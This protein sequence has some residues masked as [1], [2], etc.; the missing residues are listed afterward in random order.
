[1]NTKSKKGIIFK[2][3]SFVFCAIF[4]AFALVIAGEARESKAAL[5]Y[6]Y[7][8][9]NLYVQDDGG[10][11]TGDWNAMGIKSSASTYKTYD[12]TLSSINDINEAQVY[13][14]N[15][16]YVAS[17]QVRIVY[18]PTGTVLTYVENN[19]CTGKKYIYA[20]IFANGNPSLVTYETM[21]NN[22]DTITMTGYL[23]IVMEFRGTEKC[24]VVNSGST[25]FYSGA[26]IIY[27]TSELLY[28]AAVG[29]GY[30]ANEG[31]TSEGVLVIGSSSV[32]G[33][34]SYFSL[35]PIVGGYF[36]YYN[37][38]SGTWTNYGYFKSGDVGSLNA[39]YGYEFAKSFT[40][41]DNIKYRFRMRMYT[42]D[43]NYS[44]GTNYNTSSTYDT[45]Y[46]PYFYIDTT[47]PSYS[48]FT[49]GSSS[50][51]TSRTVTINGASDGTA[52]TTAGLASSPYCF[53]TSSSTSAPG[54]SSCSWQSSASKSFTSTINTYVHAYIRD[55][56]GNVKYA[57]YQQ[58]KVDTTNPT[59]SYSGTSTTWTASNRTITL[60]GSDSHSGVAGYYC[61]GSWVSSTAS[62]YSCTFSTT[63]K[64]ATVGVKD[65]VGNQSTATVNVYVDKTAPTLSTSGTSTTWTTSNRTITLTGSDSHSGVAGYYCNGSW[66]SSTASS[67]SCTFSTSTKTATV[68]VKDTV[69]NQTTT[70]VNVY[71]D[72]TAPSLSASGTSTTWT[73][74][75]RTITLTSSD[76]HSGVAGYYCNGSWVSSTASSYSCTF[77]TS[78]KTATVGVKDTVGNQTTT[79]VNV[80]VDKTAPS[81]SASGT[82]TTWTSSNR[83]ITLT[84]SDSHS[85]VAGYYCNGSWV[86][87]TASSY[88]CTF[89][90]TTTT[91]TVGVKDG[92]GYQTTTTVNVY[93]DKTAPTSSNIS[94]GSSSWATSRT[95][96][97]SSGA[98]S[99]SG[100]NS[101]AYCFVQSTS[102]TAPGTS[103]CS[104]Q[105]SASIKYSSTYNGYAHGY[106]RDGVSNVKY[107]SYTQ[108]KIDNTTPT[109]TI[110]DKTI[111]STYINL[112]NRTVTVPFDSLS[113]SHSGLKSI[114]AT[115]TVVSGQNGTCS[116]TNKNCVFS[117]DAISAKAIKFSFTVTDNVGKTKTDSSVTITVSPSLDDVASA[118]NT[119]FMSKLDPK[120]ES[121]GKQIT[122]QLNSE[123]ASVLTDL[124]K[125]GLDLNSTAALKYVFMV[126]D[127][128]NVDL[129]TDAD[130][131]N[132]AKSTTLATLQSAIKSPLGMK[133]DT[134]SLV[135]FVGDQAF[136]VNSIALNGTSATA[137]S[138][139]FDT[140]ESTETGYVGAGLGNDGTVVSFSDDATSAMAVTLGSANKIEKRDVYGVLEWE[141]AITSSGKVELKKVINNEYGILVLGETTSGSINGT[142]Y[143]LKGGKDILVIRL[144]KDGDILFTNV[145]GTSSDD[146]VIAGD[147]NDNRIAIISSVNDSQASLI[148][149]NVDGTGLNINTI[150][151]TALEL[152]SVAIKANKVVV[153]GTTR[154]E[155]IY[156]DGGEIIVGNV[157]EKDAFVLLFTNNNL[158]WARRLGGVSDDTFYSVS[159][160]NNNIYIVGQSN[161]AML[162]DNLG[163]TKMLDVYGNKDAMV[164]KYDYNGNL[165]Q[166]S[167]IGGEGDDTFNQVLVTDEKVIVAGK[168]SS[169]Y[170]TAS[171]YNCGYFKIN[172]LGDMD[173]VIITMDKA[174]IIEEGLNL[175][176]DEAD[177]VQEIG[178]NQYTEQ[179]MILS[180]NG[181]HTQKVVEDTLDFD[182][183]YTNGV[184]KVRANETIV[185]ATAFDGTNYYDIG[186]G[187]EL[188]EG[189]Y[190][191]KV[192][193]ASGQ[194]YS[195][196]YTVAPGL[197]P[198][199]VEHSILPMI[200]LFVSIFTLGVLTVLVIK[201][202]KNEYESARN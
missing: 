166:F 130:L 45:L 198:T 64:T 114:T 69:G 56:V 37:S 104:W 22:G 199:E 3:L 135:L 1:M 52:T 180:S 81:L 97:I 126:G 44:S 141:K 169:T 75:N 112:T 15:S 184:L 200:S 89:S 18:V 13:A 78:T 48:S 181:V 91:A 98:D 71:V 35:L 54:T 66:V 167:I 133:K 4:F 33:A 151:S 164:V 57:S 129:S 195:K 34:N 187:I 53:V 73:S 185:S 72:K 46:S 147:M 76:S 155:S 84:S 150:S 87:S 61:N 158:T 109:A 86:S 201:K 12:N 117:F 43:Y 55:E 93:V 41:S 165:T 182:I 197:V 101:T 38:S 36:E 125:L 134:I 50:W 23:T 2:S 59:L 163:S 152:T 21:Q 136:F 142:S 6:C 119:L 11:D 139:S 190:E 131:R 8:G 88:S 65:A 100:L 110:T 47:A 58:V 96:S 80:Y 171:H 175:S 74:S 77:S 162:H 123:A 183:T 106:V 17:T 157:G 10:C 99:H 24:N 153:T 70:T 132:I 79:T 138:T 121:N 192:T 160:D 140:Y 193:S 31:T 137:L 118:L 14:S 63:T 60:T 5:K 146:L 26:T 202:R 90:T 83:T 49:G 145:I 51:A 25:V 120:L 62:S 154:S 94:G 68:G 161:S 7:S 27:T 178:I 40:F 159:L 177:L 172:K 144:N 111:A 16:S 28:S 103:S 176:G 105:S 30:S 143:P 124:T 173:T 122:F 196:N 149:M 174:L 108:L 156:T 188:E 115:N 127:K 107:A 29:V 189:V 191:I 168:S 128:K 186:K 67:Y 179:L 95:V 32:V 19:N 116:T 102:T 194:T 148:T 85:G 170:V 39:T 82:S 20:N 113:D 42:V 9:G 92:V